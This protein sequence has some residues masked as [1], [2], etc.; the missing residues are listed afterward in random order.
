MGIVQYFPA[1]HGTDCCN[2]PVRG[3]HSCTVNILFQTLRTHATLH[4]YLWKLFAR[5]NCAPDIGSCD[6]HDLASFSNE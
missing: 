1:R 4:L 2:G 6:I 3:R 5:G